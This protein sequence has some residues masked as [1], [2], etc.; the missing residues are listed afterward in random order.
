MS[1][2]IPPA[3]SLDAAWLATLRIV[4]E[5]GGGTA[6]NCITTIAAPQL[7]DSQV[8]VKLDEHLQN[9]GGWSTSTVAGTIFPLEFYP[10]VAALNRRA[11]HGS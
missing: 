8:R 6:V 5:S 10:M 3:K 1:L 11:G 9:V 2:Y 4:N 7:S